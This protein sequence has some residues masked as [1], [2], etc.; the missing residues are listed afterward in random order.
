MED[1][2]VSLTIAPMAA[3]RLARSLAWDR[4][5]CHRG[6]A[7]RNSISQLSLGRTTPAYPSA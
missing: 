6:S 5:D 1:V 7:P 2:V 4:G 3:A